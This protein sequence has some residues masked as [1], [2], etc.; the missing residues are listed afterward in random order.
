M[1]TTLITFRKISK[2]LLNFVE[3]YVP[4]SAFISLFILFVVQ[5]FFRYF[6]NRPLTWPQELTSMFFVWTAL[7]G[8]SYVLRRGE[9]VVFNLIYDHV[10][11]TVKRITDVAGD[12]LLIVAFCIALKPSLEYVLLDCRSFIKTPVLRIS[13]LIVYFPFVICMPLFILH[14]CHHLIINIVRMIK[15]Y[16]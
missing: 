11:P 12:T 1:G 7:F 8:A 14:L 4:I 13:Y 6:L 16:S 9:H 15:G 2:F 10:G 3:I 5:V